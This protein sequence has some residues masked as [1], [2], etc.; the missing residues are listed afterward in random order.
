M[1]VGKE[2]TEAAEVELE[3]GKEEGTEVSKNIHL[4]SDEG[5]FV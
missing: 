3:V 4:I 5:A 1:A 2:V